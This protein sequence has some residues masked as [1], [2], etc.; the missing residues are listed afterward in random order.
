MADLEATQQIPEYYPTPFG[1]TLPTSGH[2]HGP[3]PVPGPGP[4]PGFT[5][6]LGLNIPPAEI[7]LVRA[8][9][10]HENKTKYNF[11]SLATIEGNILVMN[12]MNLAHYLFTHFYSA[13]TSTQIRLQK[14]KQGGT[15]VV[16]CILC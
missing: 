5:S 10:I 14:N 3:L 8:A 7:E 4:A 2:G 13:L 16:K 9:V 12:F 15:L 1:H 11:E 6:G